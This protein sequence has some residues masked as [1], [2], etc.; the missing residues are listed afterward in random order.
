MLDSDKSMSKKYVKKK[1]A[2]FERNDVYNRTI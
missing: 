2:K 1:N